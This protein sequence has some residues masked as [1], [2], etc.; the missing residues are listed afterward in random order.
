MSLNNEHYQ[1][2][3]LL[4]NISC[5][6][7][8]L[9]EMYTLNSKQ[10][11][12]NTFFL[13]MRML[14][15][16]GVSLYTSRIILKVLGID[17]YGIYN[18]IAGFVTFLAFISN[19]LVSAMQRYFNVALGKN[20]SRNYKEVFS[21]SINILVG[22]S[23]LILLVGET[24]GLWVVTKHLIIPIERQDA[25]MWV[26]QISLLTFIVNTLRTPFHASIIAHEK[27]SF[28]AYVSL[29]EVFLK[30]GMVFSLTIIAGDHLIMYACLYLLTMVL[31][32]AIYMIYCRN[33]FH[34]CRYVFKKDR[35]LLTDLL[36][37]SGWTMLGQASIVVKNQGEAILIN[38]F[39]TVAVNAAMGVAA[40]VANALEL[41]VSNFQ[42]AF[43]P[44]LIQSYASKEYEVHKDL[45]FRSSKFSYFLLLIMLI[46]IVGNIEFILN[47][48][49]EDVPKYTNSFVT[50]ILISYLFNALSTPFYTSLNATGMISKYQITLSTIFLCGLGLIFL[51][52]KGGAEPYIISVIAIAIQFALLIA[53]LY[54][55]HKYVPFSYKR[56]FKD[57]LFK[58]FVVTVL[59]IFLPYLLHDCS[60]SILQHILTITLEIMSTGLIIIVFGMSKTEQQIITKIILNKIVG[61]ER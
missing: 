61:K 38:R 45:L 29:F 39:F 2:I 52:L 31:V 24:L 48:W 17:D 16:L 35:D 41:F 40:Q 26:Y 47:L 4:T 30:L 32:N 51:M 42:T 55:A 46:P 53:R 5:G 12:K 19:A 10:I 33:R 25:A 21:M 27:M 7:L 3:V 50:F 9:Y 20:D 15:L 36:S 34:E 43:N 58:V 28:Y 57:V 6:C 1:D 44:Q 13:Y 56:Y 37:F 8:S 54:Y 60:G 11:A 22:F 23:F 18:L 59:S 14:L 49:L